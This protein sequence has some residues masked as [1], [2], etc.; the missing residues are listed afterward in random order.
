MEDR[1][2]EAGQGAKA[3]ASVEANP[4][5]PRGQTGEGG[6]AG[7]ASARDYALD[8]HRKLSLLFE[9][10]RNAVNEEQDKAVLR[11]ILL[12]LAE[13]LR[14]HFEQE[15]SLYY[16]TL[17]A[18]RPTLEQPLHDLMASHPHLVARVEELAGA[19]NSQARADIVMR[20][21]RF[22]RFFNQHERS[23]EQVLLSLDWELKAA[24]DPS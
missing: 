9:S 3:G 5:A 20:F 11:R 18:L 10:A 22:A 17:Y 7:E 8:A 21:E 16:P 4:P 23:E 19:T 2:R 24:R 12:Q 15:E 1:E 13:A 6:E 14:S